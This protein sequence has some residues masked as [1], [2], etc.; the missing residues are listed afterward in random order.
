MLINGSTEIRQT[1]LYL[2]HLLPKFFRRLLTIK[3]HKLY[4]LF[5]FIFFISISVF[6]QKKNKGA[7]SSKSSSSEVTAKRDAFSGKSKKGP[8]IM[9]TVE[10]QEIKP[11]ATNI[12]FQE[13]M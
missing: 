7:A 11:K 9:L 2:L 13:K 1:V 10:A 5:I 4:L 6:G 8:N 12:L 3:M